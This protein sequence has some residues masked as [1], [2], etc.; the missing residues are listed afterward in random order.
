VRQARSGRPRGARPAAVRASRLTF[1]EAQRR[2]WAN[3]VRRG[4]NTTDVAEEW[5][6][7]VA[8]LGEAVDAWRK[9]RAP[10]PGRIRRILAWLGLRPLP[11]L[12][13]DVGPV[14]LEVADV[15]SFALGVAEMTG[16]DVGAAVAEK[17]AL[18]EARSYRRLPGGAHVQVR[19]A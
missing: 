14:R 6:L 10:A 1:A 13:T 8:E 12:V 17:L 5:C 18:N 16:F 19:E 9:Y 4:F 3:K 15:I 2:V 7:L 11:P